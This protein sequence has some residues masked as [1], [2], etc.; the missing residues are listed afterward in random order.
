LRRSALLAAALLV[1][2]GLTWAAEGATGEHH[3]NPTLWKSLNFLVLA[4]GF[5]YLVRKALRPYLASRT[6][7]IQREIAEAARLR[8]QAEARAAET[9]RRLAN[10]NAEIEKLRAEARREM[11]EEERRLKA[12]S[13]RAI[14]RMQAS[15]ELEIA[16][17][18]K[19]ARQELKAYAAELAL[20]LA[21]EKIRRRMTPETAYALVDS[22]IHNLDR[23]PR[24][25]D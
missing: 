1:A 20:K 6:Q 12:E 5:A 16:S 14:A 23:N 11:D 2:A 10:L 22:F 17:L 8:E 9:D 3:G 18:T 15:A 7:A 13:E 24:R 25:P 4:A 21:R 19:R